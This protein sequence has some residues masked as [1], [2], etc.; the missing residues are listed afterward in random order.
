MGSR[1]RIGVKLAG[2]GFVVAS[3]AACCMGS[4][5]IYFLVAGTICL[6]GIAIMLTGAAMAGY[7]N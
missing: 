4:E 1:E 3:T 6:V 5:G 7:V 2:T